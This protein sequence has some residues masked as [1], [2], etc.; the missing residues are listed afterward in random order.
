MGRRPA[1]ETTQK[2]QEQ[3]EKL[4]SGRKGETL[5]F[6]QRD[7]TTLTIPI[8]AAAA[9][10]DLTIY[11]GKI[12]Q[13]NHHVVC[14]ILFF[15]DGLRIFPCDVAVRSHYEWNH[16]V[17]VRAD[18]NRN[19]CAYSVEILGRWKGSDEE[20]YQHIVKKA[21]EKEKMGLT[22]GDF[23]C[24]F[25]QYA[26]ELLG[27]GLA[28]IDD[29]TIPE[30]RDG[31]Y[32]N[33]THWDLFSSLF[34][35]DEDYDQWAG[36]R[37]GVRAVRAH[38][39]LESL[40]FSATLFSLCKPLFSLGSTQFANP[41]FALQIVVGDGGFPLDEHH[42]LYQDGR[43]Y[44]E[45]IGL[46]FANF[47]SLNGCMRLWCDYRIVKYAKKLGADFG[48][49]ENEKY[50]G[51]YEHGKFRNDWMKNDSP[52]FWKHF[53]FPLVYS[54]YH[55]ASWEN[56][57][58]EFYDDADKPLT[59][60]RFT[61]ICQAECL[62]IILPAMPRHGVSSDKNCFRI[63]WSLKTERDRT[64]MEE[65][66]NSS[67]SKFFHEH[68]RIKMLYYKFMKLLDGQEPKVL[69]KELK[70]AYMQAL[71]ECATKVERP[72]PEEQHKACLLAA[73]YFAE[74][75]FSKA[76]IEKRF[77]PFEQHIENLHKLFQCIATAKHFAEFV[78][79]QLNRA[80]QQKK[81]VVFYEDADGIYLR[82]K[83]YWEAFKQYCEKRSIAVPFSAGAFR[84]K[85]LEP[86]KY[87]KPQY[88][89]S[90][91]NVRNRYDYHKK[92]ADGEEA[93]VLNVSPSIL[94]DLEIEK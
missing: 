27:R 78:A 91:Q 88:R 2:I 61:E 86:E 94:E 60:Q 83:E 1:R 35:E 31:K 55:G 15:S 52:A 70:R 69:R 20:L 16:L 26:S 12:T 14:P 9:K 21:G 19:R 43:K 90:N 58:M 92:D 66:L 67:S 28:R 22:E 63:T 84:R 45:D 17:I 68:E 23:R 54:N 5:Y 7:F 36:G 62:P 44:R 79:E 73:L 64:R 33:F 82:Y 74:S 47:W 53:G 46:Q 34:D 56:T 42:V 6:S 4:L 29:Y 57:E 11:K 40:L 39:E 50:N 18:Y 72:K 76:G 77:I 13:K 37:Q 51:V 81:S 49:V 48:I 75:T 30:I 3:Y 71:A 80:K 89:S 41:D 59:A 65:L 32:T 85:V 87:I 10:M 8:R 38:N 93:I 25:F 24:L